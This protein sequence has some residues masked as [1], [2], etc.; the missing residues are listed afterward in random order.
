[1]TALVTSVELAEEVIRIAGNVRQWFRKVGAGLN[2]GPLRVWSTRT[3]GSAA[4]IHRANSSTPFASP[5]TDRRVRRIRNS[6]R[7]PGRGDAANAVCDH[8]FL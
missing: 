7:L 2:V 8:S 1:M 6:A 5:P 4:L 3:A